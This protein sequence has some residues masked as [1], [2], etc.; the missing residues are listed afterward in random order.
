MISPPLSTLQ[1]VC[2]G[3]EITF[4]ATIA[5]IT[6]NNFGGRNNNKPPPPPAGNFALIENI[7][8]YDS[9]AFHLKLESALTSG[10]DPDCTSGSAELK[11]KCSIILSDNGAVTFYTK[12][13]V[14]YPIKFTLIDASDDSEMILPSFSFSLFDIGTSGG[15]VC[16]NLK[17]VN[18]SSYLS[19]F[20]TRVRLGRK[21]LRH[22]CMWCMRE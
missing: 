19:I 6:H 13:N 21:I 18:E 5:N 2:A 15:V 10:N 20:N 22:F 12:A 11:K 3:I 4:D 17:N 8:S 16:V 9:Q 7:G 14:V 1:P